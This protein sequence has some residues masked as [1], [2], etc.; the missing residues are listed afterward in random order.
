MTANGLIFLSLRVD[1]EVQ[2]ECVCTRQHVSVESLM[3]TEPLAGSSSARTQSKP[4][5]SNRGRFRSRDSSAQAWKSLL[6]DSHFRRF[7]EFLCRCA[8]SLLNF[9]STFTKFICSRHKCL[10][11]IVAVKRGFES[12]VVSSTTFPCQRMAR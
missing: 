7:H 1:A 5:Y 10:A 9:Q 2:K 8:M 4:A 6:A 11:A 12:C 3:G